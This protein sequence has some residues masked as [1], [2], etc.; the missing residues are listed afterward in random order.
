MSVRDITADTVLGALHAGDRTR[1]DLADRLGVL[2]TSRWL[3]D[4]LAELGVTE[5]GQGH[6][7]SA[8]CSTC[9]LKFWDAFDLE[10]GDNVC[11]CHDDFEEN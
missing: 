9:R 10:Q 2:S 8:R 1:L 3:S 4:A 7:R 5:D 11:S 6:L